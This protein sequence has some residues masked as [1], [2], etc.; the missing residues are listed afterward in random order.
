MFSTYNLHYV[1]PC[2]RFAERRK[3]KFGRI[4][5]DPGRAADLVRRSFRLIRSVRLR[6]DCVHF[7]N[8]KIFLSATPRDEEEEQ[9]YVDE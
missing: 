8:R 4:E 2:V 5:Y 3:L 7:E 1:W 6:M 9:A